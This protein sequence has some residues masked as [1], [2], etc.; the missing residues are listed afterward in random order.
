[1][2][3]NSKLVTGNLLAILMLA[4]VLG[5]TPTEKDSKD[6]VPTG[7]KGLTIQFLDNFPRDKYLVGNNKEDIN[8][9]IDIKNEGAQT[10]G[11]DAP[12]RFKGGSVYL[13]GFDQQVISIPRGGRGLAS[14]YLPGI[15][16]TSQTG[17]IDSVKFEG[18]INPQNILV[19][20]YDLRI[21]ATV[22]Y[23]YRTNAGPSVCID[24]TP[25]DFDQGQVCEM[26]PKTLTSQG[27]PI[28]VTRIEQEAFTDSIQFKIYFENA[29]SGDVINIDKLG[30]CNP[31]S[32]DPLGREDFDR[33]KLVNVFAGTKQLQCGPFTN[34]GPGVVR[35]IDG[36][37]Y[38]ICNLD[39]SQ[40]A[41]NVAYLTSL[42]IELEYGYRSSISKPITISKAKTIN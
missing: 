13:S 34:E 10:M 33:V 36:K 38:V 5:C 17:S 3:K 25:F 19:D 41:S 23:P 7:T 18:S 8:I 30:Q 26:G 29:G 2:G 11:N 20:N 40:E 35:L 9:I 1:M 21:L 22:C 24:P 16:S 27:A 39:I 42:N 28:A 31:F 37:G 14:L 12:A 15:S 6:W 4:F 32:A